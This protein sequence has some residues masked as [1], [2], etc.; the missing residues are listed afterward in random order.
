MINVGAA[1]LTALPPKHYKAHVPKR[2]FSGSNKMIMTLNLFLCW[3]YLAPRPWSLSYVHSAAF[4]CSWQVVTKMLFVSVCYK[5]NLVL[6]VTEEFRDVEP[7]DCVREG[8]KTARVADALGAQERGW[9]GQEGW[10]LS[11]RTQ[12]ECLGRPGASTLPLA[13]LG[14]LLCRLGTS[15]LGSPLVTQASHLT[16]GMSLMIYPWFQC[17]WTQDSWNW[18][19][20]FVCKGLL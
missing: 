9:A 4:S 17:C 12:Q 16:F 20:L 18:A 5:G 1:R 13:P 15:Y 3:G 19:V 14:H 8:E 11:G 2:F 7:E 6:N 10:L